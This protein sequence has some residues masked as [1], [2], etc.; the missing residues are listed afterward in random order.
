LFGLHRLLLPVVWPSS[1]A[2]ACLLAVCF[3]FCCLLLVAC[4]RVCVQVKGKHGAG[5]FGGGKGGE[6]HI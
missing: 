6:T 2:A 1:F 4:V 3:S 5:G